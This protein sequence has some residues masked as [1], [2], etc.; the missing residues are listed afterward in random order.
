MDLWTILVISIAIYL[1]YTY[2][3][4]ETLANTETTA[5]TVADDNAFTGLT[6]LS[7]SL[8]VFRYYTNG[9]NSETLRCLINPKTGKCYNK[10]DF[11]DAISVPSCA[12]FNETLVKEIRD[13]NSTTRKIFDQSNP[14]SV[15]ECTQ[16]GL[17]NTSH[18][19]NNINNIILQ[20]D[21]SSPFKNTLVCGHQKNI[22]TFLSTPATPATADTI[23]YKYSLSGASCATKCTR[24]TGAA[25]QDPSTYD[26]QLR[27]RGKVTGPDPNCAATKAT[28]QTALNAYNK[29]YGTCLSTCV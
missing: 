24:A 18:W 29:I 27:S 19:C 9:P 22:K 16:H 3:T 5:I 14:Y 17:N 4:S 28:M 20:T 11:F 2:M 23:P 10:A 8:P 15:S 25:P 7:D 13:T 12:K 21:C 1:I 26:C 6:C